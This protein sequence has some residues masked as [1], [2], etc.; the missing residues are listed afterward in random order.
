M[1]EVDESATTDVLEL[2]LE[3]PAERDAEVRATIKAWTAQQRGEAAYWGSAMSL[4][5][6]GEHAVY[7]PIE[8]AHVFELRRVIQAW[9]GSDEPVIRMAAIPA[10]LSGI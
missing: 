6:D 8:P 10:G 5:A 2:A 3:W 4:R 1:D 9:K 7:V